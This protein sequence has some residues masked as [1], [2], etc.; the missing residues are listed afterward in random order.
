MMIL[1]YQDGTRVGKTE[2]TGFSVRKG[3]CEIAVSVPTDGLADGQYYWEIDILQRSH[4]YAREK[5]DS[6]P[7]ALPFSIRNAEVFG[8]KGE[9]WVS[10]YWGHVML[11]PIELLAGASARDSEG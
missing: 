6:I 11:R 5:C 10:A 2:S 1:F 9:R 3:A 7:N 8:V 4:Y